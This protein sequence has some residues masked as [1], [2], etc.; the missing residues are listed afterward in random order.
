MNTIAEQNDRGSKKRSNGHKTH[1]SQESSM[2]KLKFYGI[3]AIGLRAREEVLPGRLIVMEGTDSVGRSTQV[4]FLRPWLESVGYAVIDTEMTRSELAGPGLKQAKEGHTL[5]PITLNL[6]YATDFVDRFEREI[7]PAL[8]AGFIV[9]TDRYIYS[10]IAR[11]LVRGADP[12]WLRSIYGLALKPDIIF[13]LKISLDNLIPRVLQ[14]GGFDY[15]ESGMDMR[16]GAD[17]YESFVE[18]QTRMLTV[19]D[20]MVDE[21][22]FHIIDAS[23]PAKQ[24]LEQIKHQIIPLLPHG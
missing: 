11:S 8:R 23:L 10:L 3:D 18:Y 5:G 12:H 13:Y 24:M 7:L 21:Y 17:L 20:E 22:N 19:F 1:V 6:F 2:T 16:L 14:S 9:L 15:W 4:Q